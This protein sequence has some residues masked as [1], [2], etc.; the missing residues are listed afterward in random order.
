M[1]SAVCRATRGAAR[2]SFRDRLDNAQIPYSDTGN[3]RTTNN[4]YTWGRLSEDVNG[5]E[6]VPTKNEVAEG[7]EE[8]QHDGFMSVVCKGA[9]CYRSTAI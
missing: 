2:T 3:D 1:W 9:C 5:N 8:I 4:K 7:L 6:K